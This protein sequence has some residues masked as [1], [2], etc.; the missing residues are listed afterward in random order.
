MALCMMGALIVAILAPV[1]LFA[2]MY[3][4]FSR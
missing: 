3:M 4:L 2:L 1:Y